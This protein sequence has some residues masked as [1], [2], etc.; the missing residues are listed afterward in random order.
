M[1]T[2]LIV[3]IVIVASVYVFILRAIFSINL[4]VENLHNQTV[5]ARKQSEY[6][7]A[8]YNK[9]K[10]LIYSQGIDEQEILNKM[11][12]SNQKNINS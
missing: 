1:D 4:I 8:I 10:I 11:T 3:I 12:E 9:I 6:Q 2:E 7:E 5:E